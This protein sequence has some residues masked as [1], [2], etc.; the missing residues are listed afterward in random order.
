MSRRIPVSLACAVLLAASA[1]RDTT[2]APTGIQ[3]G[4]IA[5]DQGQGLGEV[6]RGAV[7]HRPLDA[8]QSNAPPVHG[9]GGSVNLLYGGGTG[10]IGVQT[11]PKIY[12]VVW[13]S[14][15]NSGDPSG[16]VGILQ[17]FYSGMGGS[18]WLNSVTQYCQGVAVGTIICGGSGVHAGNQSGLYAATWTDNAS[19]AP[20]H[21]SQN[22]LAA[23]AV[24]AA[25]HFG[26]TGAGSNNNTQY[27]IATATGNS[28]TGFKTQYCAYH[29]STGSSYGNISY[30]NLPYLTDAGASC[31]AN[32]NGLGPKA[33]ITIVSGHEAAEAITDPF[34]NSGWLDSKGAENG[35]KCAWISTGSPGASQNITLST[36]TFAIQTLWSNAFNSNAGGCVASY[37]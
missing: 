8:G 3:P 36:G 26:N 4:T 10:G 7:I 6:L 9:G 1:C 14:Q 22:E 11:A 15:W 13:G 2:Q 30:T 24:R 31:G 34:P 27:V 32:F 21:P 28:S 16:E 12:L 37:P 17:S 5:A 18:P 35:D 19:A 23:E 25:A 20:S 29:S 33:G